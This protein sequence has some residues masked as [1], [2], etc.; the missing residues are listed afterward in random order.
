VKTSAFAAVILAGGFSTRMG[1][2]KP[3]LPL[4]EMTIT[5]FIISTFRS[6][7]IE[8]CLVV[9]WK[10]D[11]LV[12]G[13]VS[14]DVKII[15]NP[16]YAR[17]MFSSVKAGVSNLPEY[18]AGFFLIP[19]D[20]P[21]VKASTLGFLLNQA[22][23]YS[24]RIIY[25]VFG[26]KRGH[27]T[28]IPASLSPVIMGWKD[29]GGLKAVLESKEDMALEVEVPDRNILFDIDTPDDYQELLKRFERYDIPTEQESL[30]ILSSIYRMEP[31]RLKHSIK[32]A[33]V[34]VSIGRSFQNAGIQVDLELVHSASL[35]H[36]VAKGQPQHDVTGARLIRELGFDRAAEI[37]GVHSNL[38]EGDASASLPLESQIVF[39]ADKLVAGDSRVSIE[40]RYQSAASR[41]GTTPELHAKIMER[42]QV[43]LKVK[44]QFEETLGFPLENII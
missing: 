3:L 28:V 40:D 33:E 15:E 10:K 24:D 25:P 14:S 4:G 19:V 38:A 22:T 21:L 18:I 6:K 5:D 32:V 13:I 17:G 7:G 2:F 36:D 43:A 16:D 23:Q 29:D 12:N 8:V 27:P 39:L 11:E 1:W 26:G 44:H 31:L 30:V 41:H 20:I 37:V 35:L 42:M 34:A 9:G